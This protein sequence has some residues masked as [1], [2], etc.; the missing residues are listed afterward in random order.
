MILSYLFYSYSFYY[1]L[2]ANMYKIYNKGTSELFVLKFH[3][4]LHGIW[5]LFCQNKLS[6]TDPIVSQKSET[7]FETI[8]R[9]KK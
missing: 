1:K 3:S 9:F 6:M 8:Q 2:V 4:K 5:A 7:N